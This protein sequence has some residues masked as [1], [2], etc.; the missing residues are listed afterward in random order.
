MH[1]SQQVQVL[2]ASPISKIT[3][4]EVSDVH[5]RTDD[6]FP[7]FSLKKKFRSR[8]FEEFLGINFLLYQFYTQLS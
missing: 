8:Q 2:C 6:T 3:N 5:L 4:F 1:I 7:T